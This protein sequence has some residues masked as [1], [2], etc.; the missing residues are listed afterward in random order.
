MRGYQR[1]AHS[2]T[3][4]L[5]KVRAL[6]LQASLQLAHSHP[7]SKHGQGSQVS[8][9]MNGAT[10]CLKVSNQTTLYCS[11]S[12]CL[13]SS[14]TNAAMS[15]CSFQGCSG[16]MFKLLIPIT[17]NTGNSVSLSCSFPF[18]I[19]ALPGACFLAVQCL[20]RHPSLG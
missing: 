14:Y 8:A 17:L 16:T 6:S 3:H 20:P 5:R 15:L 18:P 19:L 1:S 4:N 13:R 10:S 12:H 7:I 11:F 2:F 9:T